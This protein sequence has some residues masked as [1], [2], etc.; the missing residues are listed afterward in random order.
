MAHFGGAIAGAI[1]SVMLR[2]GTDIT[3]PFNKLLDFV[4]NTCSAIKEFKLPKLTKKS[5]PKAKKWDH[6]NASTTNNN[7]SAKASAS[8]QDQ[9]ELDKILDKIKKSGY[10]AL[11]SEE[12]QRLFD[13]SKRIK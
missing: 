12:K 1:Y 10:T 7:A 9:A 4:V 11:T 13:V 6:T 5:A 3:R 8:P 2:R